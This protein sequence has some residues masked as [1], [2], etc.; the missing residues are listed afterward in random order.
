MKCPPT[1]VRACNLLRSSSLEGCRSTW[2]RHE[3][4]HVKHL[5]QNSRD[6]AYSEC[7]RNWERV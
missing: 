3:H 7:R 6:E 2:H 5:H 4:F 1:L